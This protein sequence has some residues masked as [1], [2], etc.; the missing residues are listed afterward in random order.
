MFILLILLNCLYFGSATVASDNTKADITIASLD[1]LFN[2]YDHWRMQ[3]P[4]AIPHDKPF[5]LD[6]P[7]LDVYSES[8]ASVYHG[9][10]SRQNA[11]FLDALP[12]AI[13]GAKTNDPRPSLKEAVEMF[14]DFKAQE[15]SILAGK[16]YTVFAVT[17]PNWDRCKAQNE[18]VQKLRERAAKLG[19]RVLEVRLHT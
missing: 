17:Y 14:P 6:V 13:N 19:I 1:D 18:A 10:D 8:G 9:A 11:E 2:G 15:N 3:H 4:N 7:F 12:K 16:G 5:R